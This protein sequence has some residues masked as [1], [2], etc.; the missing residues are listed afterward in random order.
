LSIEQGV[1]GGTPGSPAP[2]VAIAHLTFDSVPAF[3]AAFG[4][5]A[6]EIMADIPKYTSIE[7]VI[8]ISEVQIGS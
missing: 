4:P 8:Q 5:H 3:E 2:F 7:P 6:E 1:T